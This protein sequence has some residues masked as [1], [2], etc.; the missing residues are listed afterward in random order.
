MK[1]FVLKFLSLI[2]AVVMTV[3]FAGCDQLL[4]DL[5]SKIE[6]I[7]AQIQETIDAVDY[8]AA[9]LE[10]FTNPISGEGELVEGWCGTELDAA[11]L[12]PEGSTF[13]KGYKEE[14][15]LA[16][17]GKG[18][19]YANMVT[20]SSVEEMDAYVESLKTLG[21]DAYNEK[22]TWGVYETSKLTGTRCM[23]VAKDGVYIQVA[24]FASEGAEFNAVFAI[25]N[26][27]MLEKAT[28][29]TTGGSESTE[30]DQTEGGD[31]VVGEP[32]VGDS[33]GEEGK[34]VEGEN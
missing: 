22:I 13:V 1:R 23:A 32:A 9:N 5:N 8:I 29:G 10:N 30:G 18:L 11:F 24:F 15:D 27:D 2:S 25:A 4:N 3:S 19:V 6:E 33:S 17:S 12:Q 20:L 16:D 21:Y 28:E 31:S 34:G 7:A 26:Y 14:N